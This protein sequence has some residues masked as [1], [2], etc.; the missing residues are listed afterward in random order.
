MAPL[1]TQQCE[2]RVTDQR[3]FC[4]IN[5]KINMV[6]TPKYDG[7]AACIEANYFQ[8]DFY[9]KILGKNYVLRQ[10][11]LEAVAAKDIR[12]FEWLI[13]DSTHEFNSNVH[14]FCKNEWPKTTAKSPANPEIAGRKWTSDTDDS[15]VPEQRKS[16]GSVAVPDSATPKFGVLSNNC[17]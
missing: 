8:L 9:W 6:I 3:G 7:F 4:F 1:P 17:W 2:W 14:R 13:S 5:Q 12:S 11:W 15:R 16:A 10:C